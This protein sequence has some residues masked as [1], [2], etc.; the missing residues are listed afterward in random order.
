VVARL[1]RHR[2]PEEPSVTADATA[3]PEEPAA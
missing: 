1:H 3:A 2:C